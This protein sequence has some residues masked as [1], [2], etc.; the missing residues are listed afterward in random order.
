VP[1]NPAQLFLKNQ[2]MLSVHSTSRVQ[3]EDS[4]ALIASGAIRPVV[5]EVCGPQ[6]LP[7]VHRRM[8]RGGVAGRIVIRMDGGGHGS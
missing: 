3:L 4:L 5:T 2:S 1:F 6:D 8:E 7:D